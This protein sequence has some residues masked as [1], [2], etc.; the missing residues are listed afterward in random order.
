[1]LKDALPPGVA[2]FMTYY[3]YGQIFKNS[4]PF[5]YLQQRKDFSKQIFPHQNKKQWHILASSEQKA[6]SQEKY[7]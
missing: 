7:L 5:R 2:I 1:M 3:S 6:L 4:L